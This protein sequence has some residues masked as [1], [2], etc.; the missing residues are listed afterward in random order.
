MIYLA[1]FTGV[2]SLQR[3]VL[4]MNRLGMLVDISHVNNYTMSD[5]LDTS[6]APGIIT[7]KNCFYTISFLSCVQLLFLSLLLVIF[8]HSS[9]YAL[10][11]NPR[12]VPDNILR[13]MV[14]ILS[15]T[16]LVYNFFSWVA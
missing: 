5:V 14:K 7:C 12:N 4:E 6:K 9:A 11:D 13:R 2:I 1:C 15:A 10:C 16:N 8:S 3:V